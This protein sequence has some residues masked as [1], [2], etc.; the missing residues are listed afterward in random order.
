MNNMMRWE[1]ATAMDFFDTLDLFRDEMD[2]WT[3][4]FRTPDVSG[5]FDRTV[6]PAVDV[7][8]TP[9]SFLVFADIPGI[10]KKDINITM[11]GTVLTLQGEKKEDKE[12]KDRKFFR[13][14]TWNGSFRR[15]LDLPKTADPDKVSANL[16]DGVLT[17][18]VQKRE[19]VKPR[20][21]SVNVK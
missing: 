7:V 13:K 17:I 5:I 18:T 9:E 15:T 8:E 4:A 10:D 19:E 12:E 21:I 6:T 1:P 20:M 14:E 11:T 16:K 3:N 2:R